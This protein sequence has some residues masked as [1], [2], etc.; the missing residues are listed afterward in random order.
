MQFCL[1]KAEIKNENVDSEVY[2]KPDVTKCTP[3]DTGEFPRSKP[4]FDV[5]LCSS[6]GSTVC[7]CLLRRNINEQKVLGVFKAV[8]ADITPAD[9][10]VVHGTGDRKRKARPIL[11]CFVSR[12]KRKKALKDALEYAGA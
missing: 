3:Q 7:F 11:V 1:Q 5:N 9:V 6:R 2:K 4:A 12:R 8:G 10:S